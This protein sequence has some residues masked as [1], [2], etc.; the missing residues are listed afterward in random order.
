MPGPSLV[1]WLFILIT[2]GSSGPGCY[3]LGPPRAM[4]SVA[5]NV[6]LCT[7][8]LLMQCCWIVTGSLPY[9]AISEHFVRTPTVYCGTPHPRATAHRA[10]LQR[11]WGREPAALALSRGSSQ[12]SEPAPKSTAP[13]ELTSRCWTYGSIRCSSSRSCAAGP[14][15]RPTSPQPNTTKA[16]SL[17][18]HHIP[19]HPREPDTEH[20]P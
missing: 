20:E 6:A 12:K 11:L 3:R 19:N 16:S 10:R 4:Q 9:F 15:S 17:S 14:R 13:L 1:C 18:P 2:T 7:T 5:S 8:G